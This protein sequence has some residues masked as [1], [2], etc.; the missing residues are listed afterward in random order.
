MATTIIMLIGQIGSGK[1]TW[2]GWKAAETHQVRPNYPQVGN[3]PI[4]FWDDAATEYEEDILKFLAMKII[5]DNH[6]Q[7]DLHIDEAAQA[8]LESRGSG[9][10][11]TDSRLVTMARKADVNINFA[12]QLM[13]M[14]DKRLQ[15][16]GN[17]YV[18]CDF[19]YITTESMQSFIPDFF[20]YDV[21]NE[22]LKYQKSMYLD[23]KVAE[24]YL[25]PL[26]DTRHMPNRELL[27]K[28][29][30]FYYWGEGRNSY[31]QT[32]FDRDSAAFDALIEK[33]KEVEET[34]RIIN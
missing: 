21:Y 6:T 30:L 27:K 20:S 24:R 2:I 10:K 9:L 12:T 23:G 31:N 15:W 7:M 25:F 22:S 18:V 8:G 29:F 33:Y 14:T 13:S 17:F 28:E 26:F 1:T 11:A 5:K 19:H 3:I 32:K 34:G 4:K 16:N